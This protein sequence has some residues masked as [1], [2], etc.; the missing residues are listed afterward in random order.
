MTSQETAPAE[1]PKYKTQSSTV[2]YSQAA[3]L[4]QPWWTFAAQFVPSWI[5]PNLL[6][7]LGC[8]AIVVP[9]LLLLILNPSL[10]QDLSKT[11]LV[12]Q[13][14]GIFIMQTLDAL[15]GKHARRLG[16][17]SALG[18]WLDHT[19]DIV[20]MLFVYAG[21]A[22][23]IRLGINAFSWALLLGISLYSYGLHWEESHT[24]TL[25]LGNGTSITEGQLLAILI[26]LV[27]LFYPAFW[28]MRLVDFGFSLAESLGNL[29][30]AE[31]AVIIGLLSMIGVGYSA[32]A[33]RVILSCQGSWVKGKESLRRL[34]PFLLLVGPSSLFM[35]QVGNLESGFWLAVGS[36]ALVVRSIGR[37]AYENVALKQPSFDPFILGVL[38]LQFGL[39]F[40]A[41]NAA[42]YKIFAIACVFVS[43]YDWLRIARQMSRELDVP[44]LT[45]PSPKK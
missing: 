43:I 18:S 16:L 27:S 5:S 42:H 8:L 25:V 35:A 19:L 1:K 37:L 17:S 11:I 38:V 45:V 36:L 4:L 41:D 29:R 21:V 12:A 31:W 39:V 30:A 14:F 33:W 20:S 9:S 10:D 15:D 26:H 22:A 40:L 44:L 28:D 23:S 2:D 32:S 3:E 34:L 24:G 6:T 7:V 13:I